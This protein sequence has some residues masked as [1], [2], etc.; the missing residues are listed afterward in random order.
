MGQYILNAL[1]VVG[2][3]RLTITKSSLSELRKAADSVA[4]SLIGHEGTAKALGVP[5]N[6]GML[7]EFRGGDVYYIARLKIRLPQSGDI[8]E[9][10]ED[11]LSIYRVKVEM[12]P[13]EMCPQCGQDV[14][15]EF[16]WKC[17][18]Q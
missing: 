1:P 2:E 6:R 17:A 14:Y 9:V 12:E 15:S 4:V 16:T 13:C 18:C 11:D 5:F 10:K 7:T 3:G 8:P